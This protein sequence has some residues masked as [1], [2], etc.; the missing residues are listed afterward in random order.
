MPDSSEFINYFSREGVA[1]LVL[2]RSPANAYNLAFMKALFEAI[3]RADQDTSIGSV[4]IKSNSGKFFCAGADI[5]EFHEN[6]T[7]ENQRMVDQARAVTAAI[8]S[9]N[10]IFIAQLSGHALGGGLELA[11]ACDMRFAATGNFLL[12]LSEI[13]L[14]L[15]PGNGGTQRLVR[16]VGVS[17]ALEILA[18]GDNF[19]VED[20]ERWGLINRVY[21][22]EELEGATFSYAR[23]VAAGPALAV[24]ATK[25]AVREGAQMV[26][27]D[28]LKFEQQLSDTLYDT[29]DGAEGFLAFLEKRI[30]KF[31]GK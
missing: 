30:P 17:R 15:I 9:S 23:E 31:I 27:E 29:Q 12:G 5:K 3:Q 25:K 11:M 13:K 8:E 28:G 1:C 14:G 4:I 24:A 19:S 20:A 26:L 7:A 21:Q 22:P 16:I 18:T 10:K 2:N 6:D